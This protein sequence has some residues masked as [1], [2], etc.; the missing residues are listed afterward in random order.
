[1]TIKVNIKR[2]TLDEGASENFTVT[3]SNATKARLGTNQT[4]TVTILDND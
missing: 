1:M 2:D 3:L 4:A